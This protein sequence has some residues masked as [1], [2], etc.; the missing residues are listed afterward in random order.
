MVTESEKILVGPHEFQA[1]SD[2]KP[3]FANHGASDHECPTTAFLDLDGVA[4]QGGT[5][6]D[7]AWPHDFL[8]LRGDVNV[9]PGKDNGQEPPGMIVKIPIIVGGAPVVDS[10]GKQPEVQ[11]PSSHVGAFGP[12]E[13]LPLRKA[14]FHV[15][16]HF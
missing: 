1:F 9:A 5:E 11:D 15:F 3:P 6:A 14:N 2:P 8:A 12:A 16:L 13:L 10:D 7:L 4:M